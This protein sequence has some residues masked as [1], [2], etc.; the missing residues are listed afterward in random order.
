[1]TDEQDKC[2]VVVAVVWEE[3]RHFIGMDPPEWADLLVVCCELL[4]VWC[5]GGLVSLLKS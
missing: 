2:L 3:G 1:L 4:W 5:S